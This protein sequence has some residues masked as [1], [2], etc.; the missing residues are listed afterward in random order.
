[1]DVARQ[2]DV[3]P[4]MIADWKKGRYQPSDANVRKIGDFIGY[5]P[6]F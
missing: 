4:S 3:A 6:L 2:M 1:M 5:D